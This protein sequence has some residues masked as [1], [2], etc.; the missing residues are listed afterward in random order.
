M[1]STTKPWFPV[2][3]GL[4]GKRK[5]FY[6]FVKSVVKTKPFYITKNSPH[7]RNYNK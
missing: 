5:Y 3:Y 7:F 4:T 6:L 2:L 1:R